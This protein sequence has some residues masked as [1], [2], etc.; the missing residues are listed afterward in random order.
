MIGWL[1]VMNIMNGTV[2]GAHPSGESSSHPSS[3]CWPAEPTDP[4][5]GTRDMTTDVWSLLWATTTLSLR[6]GN[7]QREKKDTLHYVELQLRK[8]TVSLSNLSGFVFKHFKITSFKK[9][10]WNE[11]VWLGTEVSVLEIC[12][13]LL[14]PSKIC[15][16]WLSIVCVGVWV[17][18]MAKPSHQR[19]HTRG[20]HWLT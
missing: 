19:I 20:L 9:D 18:P 1:N 4:W 11:I 10:H 12:H 14:A 3:L 6:L 8:A 16:T 5:R 2:E 17:F 15:V 7:L 13:L